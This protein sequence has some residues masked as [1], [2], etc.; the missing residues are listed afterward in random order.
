MST[1]L[2]PSPSGSD[3]LAKMISEFHILNTNY[4]ALSDDKWKVFHCS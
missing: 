2:H 3:N 1:E 4:R